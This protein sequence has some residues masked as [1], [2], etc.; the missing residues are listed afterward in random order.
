MG[1]LAQVQ[2]VRFGSEPQLGKQGKCNITVATATV[3]VWVLCTVYVHDELSI[4]FALVLV[5]I[6]FYR[7]VY[8]LCTLCTAQTC[9]VKLSSRL[10]LPNSRLGRK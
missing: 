4:Y 1:Q 7:V 10:A 6:F 8:L 2:E 5:S 3:L 9:S